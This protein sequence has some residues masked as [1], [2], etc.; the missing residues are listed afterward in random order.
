MFKV[1]VIFSIPC[2]YSVILS[3]SWQRA[4]ETS[5]R[6]WLLLWRQIR[7]TLF[8]TQALCTVLLDGHRGNYS[9]ALSNIHVDTH[10]NK[11]FFAFTITRQFLLLISM[12]AL[13]FLKT[14]HFPYSSCQKCYEYSIGN[15]YSIVIGDCCCP[16]LY[17]TVIAVLTS[18]DVIKLQ[19]LSGTGV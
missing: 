3:G 7:L 2:K 5:S 16:F 10:K 12:M 19:N 6:E 17:S 4:P 11:P 1:Q 14:T 9:E 13:P 18:T 8:V 15:D